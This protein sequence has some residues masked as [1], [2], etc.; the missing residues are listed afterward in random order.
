MRHLLSAALFT[1]A[2]TLAAP[3]APSACGNSYI[4]YYLLSGATR[5][6]QATEAALLAGRF[7][8][9]V[10]SSNQ[11]ATVVEQGTPVR[12][13]PGSFRGD[14][15]D[16]IEG[17]WHININEAELGDRTLPEAPRSEREPLHA[18][19]RMLRG[20]AIARMNGQLNSVLTPLRRATAEQREARFQF[21]LADLA[22]ARAANPTDPRA[23]AYEAEARARH[24]PGPNPAALATLR[25]LGARDVLADP[26]SW[27]ALARLEDN[28]AARTAALARCTAMAG[29]NAARACVP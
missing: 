5:A 20:I 6:L 14:F 16:R 17:G 24:T 27:A 12:T 13:F 4:H 15:R 22:A 28:E 26:W 10:A 3:T 21:A 1:C 7:G 18:R 23:E 29:R 2:L 25:G 19:A 8:G 11:I 9:A